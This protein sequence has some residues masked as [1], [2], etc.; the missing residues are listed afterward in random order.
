MGRSSHTTLFTDISF[1][2]FHLFLHFGRVVFILGPLK[3]SDR[4]EAVQRACVQVAWD[5]QSTCRNEIK[6]IRWNTSPHKYK[7]YHNTQ[8]QNLSSIDPPVT[9]HRSDPNASGWGRGFTLDQS[10]LYSRKKHK[11]AEKQIQNW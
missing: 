9:T 7:Q 1:S 8:E 10:P 6:Q 3:R 5:D 11:T 4:Q 2:L